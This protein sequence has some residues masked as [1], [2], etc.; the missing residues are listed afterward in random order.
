ML[1]VLILAGLFPWAYANHAAGVDASLIE[2]NKPIN[3]ALNLTWRVIFCALATLAV[4]RVAGWLVAGAYFLYFAGVFAWVFTSHLNRARFVP[5]WYISTQEKAA[6]SDRLLVK[7]AK[8][9]Q[10]PVG[11]LAQTV[12][13]AFLWFGIAAFFAAIVYNFYRY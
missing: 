8:E 2:A 1:L 9:L 13:T 5:T 12:Y 4:W 7:I 10:T 11:I 3:H 6:L